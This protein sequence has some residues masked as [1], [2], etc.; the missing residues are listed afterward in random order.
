MQIVIPTY[1]PHFIRS[2]EFLNSF[3]KHCKDKDRVTINFIVSDHE[4]SKFHSM[5]NKFSNILNI[6]IYIL[7]HLVKLIFNKDI[8]EIS[9]LNTIGKY[10]FQS[11]KKLVGVYY[12]G[13]PY[14]LLMD[15]ETLVVRDFFLK[16][17]FN[18]FFNKEKHIF[19]TDNTGNF[20]AFLKQITDDCLDILKYEEHIPYYF[21]ETYNWFFDSNILKD[22]FTYIEGSFNSTIFDLL[23]EKYEVIFETILY[24]LF[25]Y[26]NNDKYNYKFVCINNELEE[27]LGKK[28]FE[29]YKSNPLLPTCFEFH[30][31]VLNT[32]LMV[33]CFYKFYTKWNLNF[34]KMGLQN[35]K[36]FSKY[37]V[38]FINKTQSII[39]LCTLFYIP[40]EFRT[41]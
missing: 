41:L 32:E 8:N 28:E 39:F 11:L 33:D 12:I 26:K 5:T 13:N 22:L 23:T 27:I 34:V 19:Y 20:N 38:D 2:I 6:R 7:K 29:I 21:F 9:L 3:N 35:E 24:N 16:D 14:S 30:A 10:N 4:V 18:R 15:A 1:E 17:L 40:A 31:Q 25:I 37:Q 36:Q